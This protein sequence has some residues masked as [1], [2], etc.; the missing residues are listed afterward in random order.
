MHTYNI[1]LWQST[2]EVLVRYVKRTMPGQWFAHTTHVDNLVVGF[3]DCVFNLI[4]AGH[5]VTVEVL[6]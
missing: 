3:N 1:T 4:E 6:P 5:N 2:G